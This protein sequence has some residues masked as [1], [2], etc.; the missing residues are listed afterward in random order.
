M[1]YDRHSYKPWFDQAYA[2]DPSSA[3]AYTSRIDES[4]LNN[5]PCNGRAPEPRIFRIYESGEILA[6]QRIFH[7]MLFPPEP[8]IIEVRLAY[9]DRLSPDDRPNSIQQ[10]GMVPLAIELINDTP[11]GS[12]TEQTVPWYA[13]AHSECTG[14]FE[15]SLKKVCPTC[16]SPERPKDEEAKS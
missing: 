7:K 15:E 6:F 1:T 3:T 4:P 10:H 8:W 16:S 9:S 13:S 2:F 5:C 14:P 11:K 12:S